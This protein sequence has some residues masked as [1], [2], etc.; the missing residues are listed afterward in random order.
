M[1]D[2]C[3]LGFERPIISYYRIVTSEGKTIGYK[4]YDKSWWKKVKAHCKLWK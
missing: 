3:M 2:I 1:C 4:S